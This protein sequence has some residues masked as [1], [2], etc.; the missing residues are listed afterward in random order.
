MSIIRYLTDIG[1]HNDIYLLYCCRT[2]SEFLFREE[3]EQL[4][5]EINGG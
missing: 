4:S 3:L 1:W 2:T 5:V